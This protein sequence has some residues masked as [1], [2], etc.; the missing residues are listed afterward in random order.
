MMGTI[1]HL[2]QSSQPWIYN[3]EG[4]Q[5][6]LNKARIRGRSIDQQ[7]YLH[8]LASTSLPY[9]RNYCAPFN[10][11]HVVTMG[12]GMFLY[13][14]VLL[15]VTADWS[16]GEQPPGTD[17]HSSSPVFFEM[18]LGKKSQSVSLVEEVVT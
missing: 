18:D 7:I 2:A 17:D 14:S 6:V 9:F 1:E 11:N 16:K 13:D 10:S 4:A 15:L 3:Q 5:R 8:L 12:A